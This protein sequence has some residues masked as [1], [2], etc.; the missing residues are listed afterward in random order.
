[1][2]LFLKIVQSKFKMVS[3]SGSGH[4]G[5]INNSGRKQIF[6]DEKEA[7]K[8][9]TCHKRIIL[10]PRGRDPSCLRQESRPLAASKTGSPRF[11]DSVSN[12]TNL[13]G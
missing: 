12:M 3:R 2:S 7:K 6:S 4:R 5:K 8:E 11:T 10:V 13:I 1:M 9:K